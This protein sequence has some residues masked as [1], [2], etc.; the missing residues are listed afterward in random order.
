MVWET[1]TVG[2]DDVAGESDPSFDGFLSRSEHAE[3]RLSP[4][5][6]ALSEEVQRWQ[7]GGKGFL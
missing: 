3:A 2:D 5:Q 7:S 1:M 6:Q 4:Q